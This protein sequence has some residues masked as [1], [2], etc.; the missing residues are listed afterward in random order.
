MHDW[1]LKLM[2]WLTRAPRYRPEAEYKP[3]LWV[4]NG[5]RLYESIFGRRY[6]VRKETASSYIWHPELNKRI[7][8]YEFYTWEAVLMHAEATIRGTF[9]RRLPFKIYI[10]LTVPLCDCA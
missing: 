10:C 6:G 1:P 2:S 8:T 5:F 7:L 9:P 3:Q 4:Y